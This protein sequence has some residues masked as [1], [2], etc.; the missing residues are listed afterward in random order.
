MLFSVSKTTHAPL[1]ANARPFSTYLIGLCM[2]S[3]LAASRAFAQ[4]FRQKARSGPERA[5]WTVDGRNGRAK[6]RG[7]R[8]APD[9]SEPPESPR[10]PA[11]A[12]FRGQSSAADPAT[13]T[14]NNRTE[15]GRA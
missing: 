7:N 4:V 15:I 8:L 1:A 3:I 5:P 11:A 10:R 2:T 9:T 12:E 14:G 6:E 13:D